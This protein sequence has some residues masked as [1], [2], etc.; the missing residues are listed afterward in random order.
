MFAFPKALR[1][2]YLRTGQFSRCWY[3]N[4]ASICMRKYYTLDSVVALTDNLSTPYRR[5]GYDSTRGAGAVEIA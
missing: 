4:L 2:L 3:Y 1:V 5:L